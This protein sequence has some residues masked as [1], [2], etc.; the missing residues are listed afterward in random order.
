MIIGLLETSSQLQVYLFD[1]KRVE[2]NEFSIFPNVMVVN[3]E[4]TAQIILEN[5]EKEMEKRFRYLESKGFREID[6]VRDKMERIVVGIDECT[7]LTGKVPKSHPDYVTIEKARLS[8]DHLSRKAR[9]CGIHLILATQKIDSDSLDTR[10]RPSRQPILAL[11]TE[12]T[13]RTAHTI[14]AIP[15]V[16]TTNTIS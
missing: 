2:M 15:T 1:F 16:H 11:H 6:P 4:I 5:L 9:A 7:D 3:Q 14:D 12:R 13:I 8:L 10:V